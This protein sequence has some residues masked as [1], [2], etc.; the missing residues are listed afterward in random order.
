MPYSMDRPQEPVY[1]LYCRERRDPNGG[2][3]WRVIGEVFNQDL[4]DCLDGSRDTDSQRFRALINGIV[5]VFWNTNHGC[6]LA[7]GCLQ[8][9]PAPPARYSA[10]ITNVKELKH[11]AIPVVAACLL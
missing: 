10:C 4:R 1:A 8:L 5:Q 11:G 7:S 3:A 9:V 6:S 2:Y